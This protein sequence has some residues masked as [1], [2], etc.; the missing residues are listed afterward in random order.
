[1][2]QL[3]RVPGA[4][5]GTTKAGAGGEG[6]ALAGGKVH[7]GDDGAVGLFAG[8]EDEEED[9]ADCDGGGGLGEGGGG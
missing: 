3:D 2:N 4:E 1:M 8:G 9:A 6:T 7:A 5:I